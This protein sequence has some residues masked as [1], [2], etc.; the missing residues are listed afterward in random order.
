MQVVKAAN[1]PDLA[2]NKPASASSAYSGGYGPDKAVDGNNSTFWSTRTADNVG[3]WWQVDLGEKS[4][5]GK[6]E[7]M[8]RNVDGKFNNVPK[9]ITF[10]V[11][12]DGEN[13]TDIISRTDN[14]PINDETPIVISH[15]YT[16]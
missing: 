7:I 15:I 2:L 4:E 11:S 13:W 6:V 12:D 5:I 16:H 1:G 9:T 3:E 10:Q 14:V 8:F